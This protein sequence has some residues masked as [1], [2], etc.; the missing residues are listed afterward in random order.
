MST[1]GYPRGDAKKFALEKATEYISTFGIPAELV[2][3]E[4][5]E[6]RAKEVSYY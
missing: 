2:N 1:Q 5:A 4:E 6:P 3:L